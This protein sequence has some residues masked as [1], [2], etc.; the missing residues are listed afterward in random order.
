MS[1]ALN[2][3]S[4]LFLILSTVILISSI[5]FIHDG[6]VGLPLNDNN[7]AYAIDSSV[8][9]PGQSNM[10]MAVGQGE[11]PS[12]MDESPNGGNGTASNATGPQIGDEMLE[13]TLVNSAQD[14]W[15]TEQIKIFN[16]LI[17]L[18]AGAADKK[19][20]EDELHKLV[21]MQYEGSIGILFSDG[22]MIYFDEGNIYYEQDDY[23]FD[24]IKTELYQSVINANGELVTDKFAFDYVSH[25]TLHLSIFKYIGVIESA[26]VI[27]F[28]ELDKTFLLE[29]G[30]GF[31]S[32]DNAYFMDTPG[33]TFEEYEVIELSFPIRIDLG[34]NLGDMLYE[35]EDGT[36]GGFAVLFVEWLEGFFGKPCELVIIER[37]SLIQNWERDIRVHLAI[38]FEPNDEN[39]R[40]SMTSPLVPEYSQITLSTIASFNNLPLYI[41]VMEKALQNGAGEYLKELY[42]QSMKE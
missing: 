31:A 2:T 24:I 17:E 41:S 6:Y 35:K 39:E 30:S 13:P 34:V 27:V 28:T 9:D 32:F 15:E 14:E 36:Y 40:F 38:L 23:V 20:F 18:F 25:S 22:M 26:D 4:I 3:L 11:I 5:F 7:N 29:S 19:A 8:N 21:E 10:H 33:V 37:E 42:E 1:K 16:E 12:N